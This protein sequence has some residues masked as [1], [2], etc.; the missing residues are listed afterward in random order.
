MNVWEHHTALAEQ[1]RRIGVL[2]IAAGLPVAAVGAWRRNRAVLH[3][4]L[5]HAEWGVTNVGI[6]WLAGRLRD[7]RMDRL[8]DPY[9]P[10]A[11]RREHARLRRMLLL[12]T[13]LDASYVVGGLALLCWRARQR[14]ASG[15][16][17][18]AGIVVQGAALFLH[19]LGHVRRLGRPT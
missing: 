11:L 9:A 14:H 10:A 5:Q 7:R 6:A 19:D 16:G 8:P 18:S 15:T 12:N 13:A 17:A 4:G 1:A 3:F 2:S